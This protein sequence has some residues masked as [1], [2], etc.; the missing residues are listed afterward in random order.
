MTPLICTPPHRD[1]DYFDEYLADDGWYQR[2][3]DEHGV[4]DE[5]S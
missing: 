4:D 3:L 5:D 2:W 1:R